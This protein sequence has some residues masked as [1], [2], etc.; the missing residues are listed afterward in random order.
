MEMPNHDAVLIRQI[1]H[2]WATSANSERGM[3]FVMGGLRH[4]KR[5][6]YC[7]SAK[8]EPPLRPKGSAA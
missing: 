2:F 6:R 7:P 4:F 5:G 8:S 3:G 1:A